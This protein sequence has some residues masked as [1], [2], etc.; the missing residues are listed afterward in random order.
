MRRSLGLALA[1]A[2]FA[3]AP[4]HAQTPPPKNSN[5]NQPFIFTRGVPSLGPA[6]VARRKARANDCAGALNYFDQALKSTIDPEVYRDRGLCHEQLGHPFP[7]IDDYRYYLKWRSNAPDADQIRDRLGRLEEQAGVGGRDPNASTSQSPDNP[8]VSAEA[9]VGSAGVN[10]STSGSSKQSMADFE[11]D[12][13]LAAAATGSPLR[14]SSG[15][16]LGPYFGIRY[17]SNVSSDL[18]PNGGSTVKL[19]TNEVLGGAIRYSFGK[20][21]TIET[22][23]GWVG[24]NDIHV[25]GLGLY[26]GY[27]ARFAISRYTSDAI[28]LGFGAGYERYREGDTGDILNAFLPR[29]KLGYRHVFGEAIGLEFH[30]DGSFGYYWA[31]GQD[32]KLKPAPIF[33]GYAALVVGF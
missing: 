20:V 19:G 15:W 7:A 14:E 10:A 26:L 13:K 33:G 18:T 6:E 1:L 3:P 22:E 24:F 27:E 17:S 12:E 4:A 28:I 31:N 29:A 21:S 30:G 32:L 16:I 5:P 2:A 23:I 9:S 25:S 11:R 8:G